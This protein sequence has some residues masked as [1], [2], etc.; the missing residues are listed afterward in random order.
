MLDIFGARFSALLAIESSAAMAFQPPYRVCSSM[1]RSSGS[2]AVIDAARSGITAGANLQS[3]RCRGAAGLA[4]RKR[5][6]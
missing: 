1:H 6:W 5:R 2:R 3:G 4:E